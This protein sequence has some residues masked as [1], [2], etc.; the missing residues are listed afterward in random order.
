MAGTAWHNY[1]GRPSTLDGVREAYPDK[2]IFFTEA[3]IGTW[4]YYFGKC[5]VEDFA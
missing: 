5:V 3:S 2:E 1:G 4:N